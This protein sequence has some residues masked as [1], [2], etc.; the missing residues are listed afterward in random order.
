MGVPIRLELGPRDME[1]KQAVLVRRDTGEKQDVPETEM[2]LAI[3]KSGSSLSQNLIKRADSWFSSMIHEARDMKELEASLKKGGLTKANFCSREK[4]G[5]YCAEKIKE[6]LHA[7]VRGT[8]ADTH[9]VP[10]GNCVIC[11]KKANAVVY[12]GRQY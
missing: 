10:K 2:V 9:E 12:V 1:R 11:G 5:R 6:K 8:R 4:E 7:E 3:R